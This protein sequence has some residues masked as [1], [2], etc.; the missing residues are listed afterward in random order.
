MPIPFFRVNP[1]CA[2]IPLGWISP[3]IGQVWEEFPLHPKVINGLKFP[4]DECYRIS[5]LFSGVE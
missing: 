1:V 3:L 5:H 4:L 2:E